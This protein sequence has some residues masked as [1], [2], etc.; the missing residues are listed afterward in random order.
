MTSNKHNVAPAIDNLTGSGTSLSGKVVSGTFWVLALRVSN[1]VLGLLRTFLLARLL[2]PQHFGIMGIAVLTISILET[3]CQPGFGAAIIQKKGEAEDYLDTL[4]M[5]SLI[6]AVLIFA[7]LFLGAPYF[8]SFFNTPQAS[9]VIQVFG[10]SVVVAGLRNP[11]V[12]L[13]QKELNFKKQYLYELSITI[14]NIAVALPAVFIFKSV[15][16][17]VLGGMAGSLTRLVMSYVLHPYRPRLRISKEKVVELLGFGKWIFGSSILYFLIS[18]GDD[19]LVGKMFGPAAL[20]IYQLA[21]MISNLTNTEISHVISQVTFPAY[22]VIQDEKQRFANAYLNVL[23][24]IVFLAVPLAG[25]IFVFAPDLIGIFLTEKWLPTVPLIKVLVWAGVMNTLMFVSE[26]VFNAAGIPKYHTKWQLVT[27]F[28]FAAFL[29]PLSARWGMTGTA[30]SLLLSNSVGAFGYFYD[31][32]R[33]LN[34]CYRRL[35]KI[36]CFPLIGMSVCIFLVSH[37]RN[38]VATAN[39]FDILF[40]VG[41]GISAYLIVIYFFDRIWQYR[42]VNIVKDSV[43]ILM[44]SRN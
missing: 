26:P 29:Y 34:C 36:F 27:F 4:W 5:S 23:Q 32:Q 1:R 7:V 17:L 3:F 31:T 44:P 13:F 35:L 10:I 28:V 38:I 41:I 16:A 25:G 21:Y 6:R 37:I 11:G 42:M 30:L 9:I 22:S 14:G 24:F 12:I 43:S 33:V 15:W 19:I 40:L 20:G 2:E 18:Q 39:I 8:A